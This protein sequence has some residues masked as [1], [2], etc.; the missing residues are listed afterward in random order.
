VQPNWEVDPELLHGD[1]IKVE[2]RKKGNKMNSRGSLGNQK[3]TPSVS[4]FGTTVMEN[5]KSTHGQVTEEAINIATGQKQKGRFK[6]KRPRHDNVGISIMSL[7]LVKRIINQIVMEDT[8]Q[9]IKWFNNLQVKTN[10]LRV[11]TVWCMQAK[12]HK[13]LNMKIMALT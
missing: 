12:E 7:L 4:K 13:S 11:P 2:R 8:P 5:I 10:V 6:K 1:W 9:L 3:G